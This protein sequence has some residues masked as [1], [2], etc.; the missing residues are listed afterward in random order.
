MIELNSGDIGHSVD[1]QTDSYEKPNK[2][3]KAPLVGQDFLLLVFI[4]ISSLSALAALF[5]LL[6]PLL[7]IVLN[8]MGLN[9]QVWD[10]WLLWLAEGE[11]SLVVTI[12]LGLNALLF[13]FL[14]RYRIRRD[15][16]VYA[17]AGCPQCQEHELIRVHRNRRDRSLSFIGLPVC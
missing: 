4:A 17:E 14:A 10:Q 13:A 1:Y 8:F 5:V 16:S 12:G 3:A 11:R 7:N 15:Y 6:T 2:S 9:Y